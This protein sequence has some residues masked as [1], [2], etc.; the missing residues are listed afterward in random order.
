MIIADGSGLRTG[1]IEGD[2]PEEG[3]EIHR[4]GGQLPVLLLLSVPL[5]CRN[6]LQNTGEDMGSSIPSAANEK[7]SKP[8][9][10]SSHLVQATCN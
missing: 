3:S 8:C 6:R 1:Q 2:E 5:I 9:V 7:S 10:S 4:E